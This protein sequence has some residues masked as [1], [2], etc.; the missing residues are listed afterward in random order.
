MGSSAEQA[1]QGDDGENEYVG[2][3]VKRNRISNFC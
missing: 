2:S 1:Q 3:T